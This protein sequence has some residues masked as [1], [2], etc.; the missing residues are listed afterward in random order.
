MS[1]RHR[2]NG[3]EVTHHSQVVR[4]AAWVAEHGNALLEAHAL[5]PDGEP[6]RRLTHVLRSL[7]MGHIVVPEELAWALTLSRETLS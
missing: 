5:L 4:Q 3:G 2:G 1:Q 7:E 6:H